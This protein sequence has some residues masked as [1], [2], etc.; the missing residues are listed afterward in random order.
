MGID[1]THK[2]IDLTD[3]TGQGTTIRRTALATEATR[4]YSAETQQR[5]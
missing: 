1:K 3:G 2:S 4:D 5:E